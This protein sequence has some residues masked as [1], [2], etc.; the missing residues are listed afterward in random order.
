[1]DINGILNLILS[2]KHQD[3]ALNL[4]NLN[5]YVVDRYIREMLP[6]IDNIVNNLNYNLEDYRIQRYLVKKLMDDKN[7]VNK[8]SSKIIV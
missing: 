3:P 4:N 8:T 1:M 2:K 6:R 5:E 7:E